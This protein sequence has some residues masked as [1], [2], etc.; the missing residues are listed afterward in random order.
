M[1]RKSWTLSENH[2][3]QYRLP[4]PGTT[5]A[6]GRSRHRS[7]RDIDY[8]SLNNGL[9][10]GKLKSP[11]C[12]KRA[13]HTPNQKDPSAVCVAAQCVNSPD[14]SPEAETLQTV[15]IGIQLPSAKPVPE[16]THTAHMSSTLTGVQPNPEVLSSDAAT[17]PAR[18][19][20]TGT[21]ST[22]RGIQLSCELPVVDA[23]SLPAGSALTGVL[24]TPEN[25][26]L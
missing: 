8:I 21:S 3:Q 6:S 24:S 2:S 26:S 15:L 19:S 1:A 16:S 17:L 4:T 7:R 13:S 11:K 20:T 25:A 10:D 14:N 12:K 5:T 18:P 22:L 9:D 23:A